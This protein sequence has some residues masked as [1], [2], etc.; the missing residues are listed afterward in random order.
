MRVL[1]QLIFTIYS[2][3]DV[4]YS[5]TLEV[6]ESKNWQAEHTGIGPSWRPAALLININIPY[7][8]LLPELKGP[9]LECVELVRTFDQAT[10]RRALHQAL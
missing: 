8:K 9:V 5:I 2:S 10:R 6:Q 3:E 7:I 1:S 4:L